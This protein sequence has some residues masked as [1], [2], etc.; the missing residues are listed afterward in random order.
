MPKVT[1]PLFSISASG[2]VGEGIT[3]QKHNIGFNVHARL[4][5]KDKKT[6]KQ[7][8]VRSW[9]K[10]GYYVWRGNVSGYGYYLG[11]YLDGLASANRDLWH[12]QGIG[13]S[14]G[15]INYFLKLWLKRSI[16]GLP[17]YQLPPAT[18]FCL[19]GEWTSGELIAG[20]KFIMEG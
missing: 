5:V 8:E 14:L 16:R 9:W 10:K 15:K 6:N 13:Q 4:V 19:S 11:A 18:G 7:L 12:R 17:Q 20:G 2:K 1:G 3:Y